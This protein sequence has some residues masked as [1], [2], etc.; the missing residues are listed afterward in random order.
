MSSWSEV[1]V[2]RAPIAFNSGVA[3]TNGRYRYY[4][5]CTQ[6]LHRPLSITCSFDRDQPSTA[7]LFERNNT[8][9]MIDRPDSFCPGR[10]RRYDPP[11]RSVVIRTNTA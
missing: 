9:A 5:R 8:I 2:V 4:L 11:R 6:Q 10:N 1:Y 3:Y 7:S